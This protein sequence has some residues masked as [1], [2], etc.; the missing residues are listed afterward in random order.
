MAN[1]KVEG[2]KAAAADTWFCAG[3]EGVWVLHVKPIAGACIR[4]AL[5][6][7]SLLYFKLFLPCS[8]SVTCFGLH[9]SAGVCADF[10]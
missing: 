7:T 5:Q 4:Q 3:E 2:E 9:C 6:I 10:F 1:G 8:Q